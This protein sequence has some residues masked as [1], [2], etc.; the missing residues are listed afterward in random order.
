M[1]GGCLT[2]RRRAVR[3]VPT[4]LLLVAAACADSARDSAHPAELVGRWVRLRPDRSWGD[5]MEFRPDGSLLGSAGY[6]V[7]PT[8]R[9]EVKRSAG[10]VRQ[11]CAAQGENGFCRDY[12]ISG[13]TLEMLGGP[14]GNTTF[15]RVR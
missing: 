15:R 8:L 10:G 11:Y 6:P 12:H 1:T 7:P 9:W 2:F 5:T 3:L 4:L 13:D 14:Q